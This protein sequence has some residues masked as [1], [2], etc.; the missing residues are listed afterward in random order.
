MNQSQAPFMENS[1]SHPIN[2]LTKKSRR[3]GLTIL[4]S[5]D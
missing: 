1:F 5:N 4:K 3:S 2:D